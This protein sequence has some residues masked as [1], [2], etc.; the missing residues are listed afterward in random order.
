MRTG[1]KLGFI[2]GYYSGTDAPESRNGGRKSRGGDEYL[3]TGAQRGWL[4][5]EVGAP[6][7]GVRSE[8]AGET[9]VGPGGSREAGRL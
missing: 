5:R 6:K 3:G 9:H 7:G 2:H 1:E 4:D 8:L